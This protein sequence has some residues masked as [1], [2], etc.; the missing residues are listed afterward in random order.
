MVQHVRDFTEDQSSVHGIYTYYYQVYKADSQ[1]EAEKWLQAQE[2]ISPY[3]HIVCQ[4]PEGNFGKNLK[5]IYKDQ[6]NKFTQV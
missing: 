5:G 6:S 3:T 4:T 1:T 2:V